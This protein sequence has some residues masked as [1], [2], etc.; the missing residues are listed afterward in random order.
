M[1]A[2]SEITDERIL[3]IRNKYQDL[4]RRQ[5]NHRGHGGPAYLEDENGENTEIIRGVIVWV[6]KRVD[7]SEVPVEDRIP[8]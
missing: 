1:A 6:T 7:Q 2:T 3:E 8:D 4:I 5:P